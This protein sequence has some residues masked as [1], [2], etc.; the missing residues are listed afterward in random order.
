[1]RGHTRFLA[2]QEGHKLRPCIF[3]YRKL[4]GKFDTVA[5][6]VF[7]QTFPVKKEVQQD[8]EKKKKIFFNASLTRTTR[9]ITPGSDF[10][11]CIVCVFPD[12][13]T[14]YAKIVT[15]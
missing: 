15:V 8:M 13:V 1:M 2:L 14:P 11:P 7:F 3:P 10:V 6:A 5:D 9:G 12:E 4:R